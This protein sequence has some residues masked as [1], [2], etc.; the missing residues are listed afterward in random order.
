M[1]NWL[2]RSA[3]RARVEP[4]GDVASGLFVVEFGVE[5]ATFACA[6]VSEQVLKSCRCSLRPCAS[7]ASGK[8]ARRL[9]GI[10][11][12]NACGRHHDVSILIGIV[13]DIGR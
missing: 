9:V 2:V 11:G 1:G 10:D 6:A 7:I 13:D 12:W 5:R 4:L 8:P 3:P